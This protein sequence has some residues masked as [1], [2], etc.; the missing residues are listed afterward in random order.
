MTITFSV[1]SGQNVCCKDSN[2]SMADRIH[3]FIIVFSRNDQKG[4]TDRIIRYDA[5]TY[6]RRG[7]FT[8]NAYYLRWRQEFFA[9][10]NLDVISKALQSIWSIV[11]IRQCLIFN[12]ASMNKR[13]FAV[14]QTTPCSSNPK[15]HIWKGTRSVITYLHP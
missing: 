1:K 8:V 15:N 12:V 4:S 14:E 5:N 7:P 2:F 13:I 6:S 9:E 3:H 10:T 11:G